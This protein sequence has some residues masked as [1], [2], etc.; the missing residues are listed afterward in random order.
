MTET[1]GRSAPIDDNGYTKYL[2]ET[3][4]TPALPYMHLKVTPTLSA[5][6]SDNRIT[7]K[8]A[9]RYRSHTAS[10]DTHHDAADVERAIE[11]IRAREA[12]RDS[13]NRR[14]VPNQSGRGRS[15]TVSEE[16]NRL[17]RHGHKQVPR[18]KKAEAGAFTAVPV[19][20]QYQSK[21]RR[22]PES[23]RKWR[24]LPDLTDGRESGSQSSLGK[25]PPVYHVLE[26]GSAS[27]IEDYSKRQTQELRSL[28]HDEID[29]TPVQSKSR[30]SGNGNARRAIS[31][32]SSAPYNPTAQS[33]T[34]THK[35]DTVYEPRSTNNQA[36]SSP[37]V[38]QPLAPRPNQDDDDFDDEAY[39]G[40]DEWLDSNA[41]LKP[42]STTSETPNGVINGGSGGKH[43]PSARVPNGRH[44]E[45]DSS[46]NQTYI[47]ESDNNNLSLKKTPPK[48]INGSIYTPLK[49]TETDSV[50]DI[51]DD[52]EMENG[53]Y[54]YQPAGPGIDIMA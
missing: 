50:C 6:A 24:S 25:A 48:D 43:S 44:L 18:S 35:Y 4:E 40:S 54:M 29:Q 26:S 45:N 23:V 30:N 1:D 13:S 5:P 16:Y 41:Y 12:V 21:A 53:E 49:M 14:F 17:T 8:P 34:M 3:E 33:D 51:E 20:G 9:H 32:S 27:S 36:P 39:Q 38:Y 46:K 52:D 37:G 15:S 28:S 10:S 22:S 47:Y 7:R 11:R 31:E 42:K 2:P 19:Y